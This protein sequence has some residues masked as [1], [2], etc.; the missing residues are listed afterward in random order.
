MLSYEVFMSFVGDNG[1]ASR[2]L[3]KECFKLWVQTR[4]SYPKQPAE[5]FRRVLTAHVC[6]LD[7]RKPFPRA[8]EKSLLP[9]LRQRRPWPCFDDKNNTIGIRGFRKLGYYEMQDK[10]WPKKPRANPVSIMN[11]VLQRG[12]KRRPETKYN[13]LID[14]R[15]AI[16]A[17][18]S[19]EMCSPRKASLLEPINV[20]LSSELDNLSAWSLT[21]GNLLQL[22][23]LLSFQSTPLYSPVLNGLATSGMPWTLFPSLTNL[24]SNNS[25]TISMMQ[26]PFA[27]YSAT[28]TW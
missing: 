23:P 13:R 11:E 21:N 8:V 6:G 3:S 9:L 16:K 25:D 19:Q 26:N 4:K 12:I 27:K 7:G 24:K 17:H 1:E 28:S 22:L 2:M 20:S 14:A 5:S 15:N 10:H 18:K